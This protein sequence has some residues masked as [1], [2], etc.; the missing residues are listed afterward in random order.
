MKFDRSTGNAAA[1]YERMRSE[2]AERLPT[3]I[4]RGSFYRLTGDHFRSWME[5]DTEEK[6]SLAK[7]EVNTTVIASFR[8]SIDDA[9]SIHGKTPQEAAEIVFTKSAANRDF[10]DLWGQEQNDTIFRI[11]EEYALKGGAERARTGKS[12]HP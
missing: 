4:A 2:Y 7:Q 12:C 10:L 5:K 6:V 9:V 8:N 3:E 11:A 1:E